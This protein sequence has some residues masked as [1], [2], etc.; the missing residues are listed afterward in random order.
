MIKIKLAFLEGRILSSQSE[1][2]ERFSKTSDW[3]EKSRPLKKP[4]LYDHVN[5]LYMFKTKEAFL[6]GRLLSSQS[7]QSE[8]FSK[9]SDWLAGKEPALQ[10]NHFC[11]IM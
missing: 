10:K 1:Q 5:R 7:E 4:P 6:E 3:L 11:L 8:N 2:S 9:S